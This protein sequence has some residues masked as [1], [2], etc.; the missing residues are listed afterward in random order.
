M[1]KIIFLADDD[2]DDSELFIECLSEI[3][4]T[5]VCHCSANGRDALENLQRQTKK[6]DVIFLDINMP[7]MNGWEC[8]VQI[9]ANEE[10]KEIPVIMYSTSSHKHDIDKA[11]TLGATCFLIKPYKYQELKDALHE[12]VSNL[13]GQNF[14]EIK[15][16]KTKGLTCPD[17][18]LKDVSAT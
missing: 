5:V 2:L 14:K 17:L 8:I 11:F 7:I 18:D 4:S 1:S 3:D 13:E 9:K 12:V 16:L 6:P 10:L 15:G